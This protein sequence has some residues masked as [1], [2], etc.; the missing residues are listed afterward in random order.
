MNFSP[1]QWRH[2]T[3]YLPNPSHPTPLCTAYPTYTSPPLP[4]GYAHHLYYP[5]SGIIAPIHPPPPAQP[6]KTILPPAK[7]ASTVVTTKPASTVVAAKPASTVVTTTTTKP[8]TNMSS[9]PSLRPGENYMFPPQHTILHI[10]NKASP[11]WEP[12]YAGQ[13]LAFKMFKVATSF[14]VGQVIERVIKKDAEGC[15]GWSV[16]EVVECGEGVWKKGSSVGYGTDKA[17]GS[18]AGMGWGVKRGAVL[19]PVWL[20]VTKD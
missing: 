9:S 10:F 11:I 14:T 18:L 12:K 3:G 20:V 15:V 5:S 4:P 13:G 17:K 16:T 19:P 2:S 1:Y 7:P 8:T 6:K